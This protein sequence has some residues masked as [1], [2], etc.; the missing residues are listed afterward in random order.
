MFR[1]MKST[2]VRAL[3]RLGAGSS[4]YVVVKVK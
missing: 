3:E 2:Q 4:K 1:R